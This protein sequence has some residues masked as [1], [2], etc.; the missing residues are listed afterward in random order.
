MFGANASGKS[1]FVRAVAFVKNLI[2]YGID[3]VVVDRKYFRLSPSGH[4]DDGLF[5]FD[6]L[7]REDCSI[8]IQLPF[9]I[10]RHVLLARR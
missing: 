2:R 6:I 10:L 5:Q 3:E 9:R 1:N 8:P 4:E 7:S